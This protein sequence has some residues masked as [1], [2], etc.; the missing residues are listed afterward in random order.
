MASSTVKEGY[1]CK[2]PPDDKSSVK[3]W[4]SRW[5]VLRL[6]SGRPCLEYYEGKDRKRLKGSIPL[7]GVRHIIRVTNYPKYFHVF[8]IPTAKRKFLISAPSQTELDAWLS[9]LKN[10]LNA[11]VVQEDARDGSVRPADVPAAESARAE[12][13][14]PAGWEK[15]V[16]PSGRTYFAN[17]M[18][19]ATQYDDPRIHGVKAAPAPAPAPVQMPPT[20]MPPAQTP[21]MSS[22]PPP[23]PG[24]GYAAYPAPNLLLPAGWEKRSDPSG[25]PYFVNHMTKTTQYEDPRILPPGW[26]QRA[27]PQGMQYFVDHIT[28]QSTYDDPRLKPRAGTG[29]TPPINEK[30]DSKK[31][32]STNQASILEKLTDYLIRPSTLDFQKKIGEGAFGDVWLCKA[33]ELKSRPGLTLAAVKLM[34]DAVEGVDE[35]EVS[36]FFREGEVMSRFDHPHIIKL[37]GVSLIKTPYLLVSEYMNKGDLKRLLQNMR[38]GGQVA[39]LM[40]KLTCCLHTAKG[41]LYLSAEKSFVHRDLAAR[42]VL[43]HE[44][45]PE[46]WECKVTDFGLSRDVYE[47]D[48]Y[49]HQ[50]G[51]V[52]AL[53]P[54]K[55]MAL[56]SLQDHIY[57]HKTDVWGFGVLLWEVLS[58]GMVPY[59]G[60]DNRVV[61][62]EL[63]DGLQLQH[64]PLL[65]CPGPIFD[66]ILRCT[67]HSPDRRPNF[68]KICERLEEE[69]EVCKEA[70]QPDYYNVVPDGGEYTNVP[71]REYGRKTSSLKN[72]HSLQQITSLNAINQM[73]REE[74]EDVLHANFVPFDYKATTDQLSE[75]L[76][77][78]WKDRRKGIKRN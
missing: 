4:R 11:T 66:L 72:R 34:R 73:P 27:D 46:E 35:K 17:H 16:D 26:E 57:T 47:S 22:Q 59:P 69:I 61:W 58:M 78:L 33:K 24:P 54:V 75:K 13:P 19:K 63:R 23:S 60:V 15:R 70:A 53:L 71:L 37:L 6:Q 40:L 68:S 32:L 10:V 43:V 3:H 14:L 62:Q 49:R 9:G 76:R 18:L 38:L 45:G 48:Y 2:S 30:P 50:V 65:D 7:E 42:N 20:L 29:P 52:K 28:Q 25:K 77:N 51:D 36:D 56:E 41:M 12:A 39:A 44:V 31:K 8:A 64:E 74:I 55:W 67:D 21:Y 5:L 1:V